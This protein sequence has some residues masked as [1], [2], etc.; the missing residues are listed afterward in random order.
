MQPGEFITVYAL[1]ADEQWYRRWQTT[2]ESVD[3]ECIITFSPASSAGEHVTRGPYTL[4][5]A[6]R[7]CYWLAKPYNLFEVLNAD[8]SANEIYLNVASPPRIDGGELRYV[9]YELDVS[10]IPGQPAVIVDQDEFEEAIGAYGYS[11]DFQARCWKAAEEA[12]QLA[13]RW[14]IGGRT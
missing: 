10:L 9:D 14:F 8:G 6:M 11:L 13:E 7:G 3:D 12:R 1:H 4:P 2:V 5:F